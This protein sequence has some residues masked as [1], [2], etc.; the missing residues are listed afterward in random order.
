MGD[1]CTQGIA[2]LFYLDA[3]FHCK[4]SISRKAAASFPGMGRP[5]NVP[6]AV[7]LELR[8]ELHSGYFCWFRLSI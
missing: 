8:A 5:D 6:P 1:Y 4:N 7:N 3:R 2:T